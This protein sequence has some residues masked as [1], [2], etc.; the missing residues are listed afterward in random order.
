MTVL[1]DGEDSKKVQE[2][3]QFNRGIPG[4]VY[5]CGGGGGDSGADH[6]AGAGPVE[7]LAN[8]T[9]VLNAVRQL[10]RANF[11]VQSDEELLPPLVDSL[12]KLLRDLGRPSRA[13]DSEGGSEAD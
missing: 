13:D 7:P 4:I 6:A 12:E 11:P 2:F 8:H 9:G 3:L 1:L 10:Y 5:G